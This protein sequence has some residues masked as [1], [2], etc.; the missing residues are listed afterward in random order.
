MRQAVA[1][2][3]PGGATMSD[4]VV[5]IAGPTATGKSTLALR[6]AEAL[7]G[8]VINADAL[9]IYDEL[10]IVTA[11]PEPA[12][13]ARVPHRLYGVLSAAE[14]CTAGRWRTMALDAIADAQREGRRPILVGGSGLYL[15]ALVA[16]LSPVPP[17]PAAIRHAVAARLAAL[18]GQA[19]HAELAAHDPAMAARLR[20]G[21]TQRL[22]R[23]REVLEATGRSLAEWQAQPRASPPGLSFAVYLMMPTRS[24]VYDA[25][26]RRFAGMVAAGAVEEVRRLTLLRLD[27]A[28]PAMK[29]VG[30]RPLLAHLHGALPLVDSVRLGQQETRQYAKRQFTWFRNRLPTLGGAPGLIRP[31]SVFNAQFS[32]RLVMEILTIVQKRR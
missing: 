13:E 22:I 26:D 12:D 2:C 20:P 32:E 28:L 10:R 5:V 23:A 7:D 1:R 30:V 19:F 21:D 24:V 18:G 17:V 11:R 15:E 31:P 16:G 8:V 25:C 3:P 14:R 4:P 29:S 6:L 27:P 9:Q